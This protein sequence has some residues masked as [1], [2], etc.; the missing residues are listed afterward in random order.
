[1]SGGLV[2]GNGRTAA[3]VVGQE[4]VLHGLM[5]VD[6]AVNKGASGAPVLD[7]SG[8]VGGMLCA[9]ASESGRFEGVAYALPI[10]LLCSVAAERRRAKL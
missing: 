4:A 10:E 5:Q 3:R 8:C 6:L 7:S 2:S 1:M 9:I